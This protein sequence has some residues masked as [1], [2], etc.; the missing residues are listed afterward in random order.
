MKRRSFVFLLAASAA[1]VVLLTTQTDAARLRYH[2]VPA[3]STDDAGAIQSGAGERLTW[4][5]EWESYDHPAPRATHL[6]TFRHPAT[7]K[8]LTLPLA[9]PEGTPQM[10]YRTNRVFYDYTGYTVEVHFL[11]DG[12]ADVI[13]N[14]G[15]LVRVAA[16]RNYLS[17]GRTPPTSSNAALP[18]PTARFNSVSTK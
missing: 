18:A 13:Y 1:V 6:V 8:L 12:S 3:E 16:K 7:G 5:M 15:L 17:S 2:F 9:L 10:A 14:S 11:A 4:R